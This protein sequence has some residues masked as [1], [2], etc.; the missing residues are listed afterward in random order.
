MINQMGFFCNSQNLFFRF[1]LAQSQMQC[2][3]YMKIT[4]DA[5]H[6]RP[7]SANCCTFMTLVSG[8][9]QYNM[10]FAFKFTELLAVPSYSGS[11]LTI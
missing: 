7:D 5:R 2:C 3:M 6:F 1:C 8:F 11:Q 9:I 10:M 4:I